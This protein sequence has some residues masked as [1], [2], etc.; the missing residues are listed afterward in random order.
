MTDDK[1][2]DNANLP[3]DALPAPE[4]AGIALTGHSGGDTPDVYA[5]REPE[6]KPPAVNV[7][8]PVRPVEN[9]AKESIAGDWKPQKKDA[10]CSF[11]GKSYSDV[12]P[13]IAGPGDIYICGECIELCQ[14]ILMQERRRRGEQ[15]EM[16]EKTFDLETKEK[17]WSCIREAKE[18][19]LELHFLFFTE[20]LH[21]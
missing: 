2:N 6:P 16:P 17:I 4:A 12:G 13:L 8:S 19:I 5:V 11:C 1:T 3:N 7:T 21:R 15:V 18:K 20:V 9:R 14:A 10:F